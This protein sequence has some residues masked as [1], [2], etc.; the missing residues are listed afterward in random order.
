MLQQPGSR[1]E[2]AF[3]LPVPGGVSSS[4]DSEHV[5]SKFYPKVF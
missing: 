1:D 4:V 3:H 2:L 5:L